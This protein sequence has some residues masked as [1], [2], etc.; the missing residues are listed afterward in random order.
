MKRLN[1]KARAYL[2][3]CVRQLRVADRLEQLE[4]RRTRARWYWRDG[5]PAVT[6]APGTPEYRKQMRKVEDA[7]ATS[8]VVMRTDLPNGMVVS[9]V[10][11]GLDHSM[12]TGGPPRIFETMVFPSPKRFDDLEMRRYATEA[13][14]KAGHV[15]I[16]EKW[17]DEPPRAEPDPTRKELQQLEANRA[18]RVCRCGRT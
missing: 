11:L 5:R 9:T 8:R 3:H 1:P 16:A 17:K 2:M 4:L 6:A 14:A 18:G 7:M 15:E 12:G 13:Q 10:W